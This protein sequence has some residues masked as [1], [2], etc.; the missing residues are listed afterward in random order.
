MGTVFDSE[1]GTWIVGLQHSTW[2][3]LFR[4]FQKKSFYNSRYQKSWIFFPKELHV[5]TINSKTAYWVNALSKC[6]ILEWKYISDF[7]P[8]Y[9]S[10]WMAFLLYCQ[11][12]SA[13]WTVS[14]PEGRPGISDISPLSGISGLS[15][16]ST[17]LIPLMF[18]SLDLLLFLSYL[19]CACWP[20]LLNFFPENSSVFFIK[21]SRLFWMAPV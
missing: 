10:K 6:L 3:S 9:W 17:L 4:H 18:F 5:P 14:V 7:R 8:S 13:F 21:K 11:C 1:L 12:H 19:F 16:D 2:Y 15:F 20:I